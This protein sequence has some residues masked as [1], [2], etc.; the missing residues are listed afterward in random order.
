MS[1]L[2]IT[3]IFIY[4]TIH[5][6]YSIFG[7]IIYVSQLICQFYTALINP[8]IPS[9]SYFISHNSIL[10]IDCNGNFDLYQYCGICHIIMK[11]N[12][13]VIHCSLCNICI[14]KH[15]HHC[16][17]IGKCIGKNNLVSFWMFII[18]TVSFFFYNT[19]ILFIKFISII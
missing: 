2:V 16:K 13:S 10:K 1:V 5:I 12:N 7:I 6:I 14:E 18:T 15:D 11:N 17:W 3:A 9:K 4:P 8:G 19:L